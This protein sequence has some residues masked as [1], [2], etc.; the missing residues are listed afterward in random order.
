MHQRKMVQF[1][2]GACDAASHSFC[3][4]RPPPHPHR[5]RSG[6]TY[7]MWNSVSLSCSHSFLVLF[8]IQTF[9]N[10]VRFCFIISVRLFGG[11]RR[12]HRSRLLSPLS[13]FLI[14][15]FPFT[16]PL[17]RRPA[18][19]LLFVPILLW[20]QSLLLLCAL[21]AMYCKRA[22]KSKKALAKREKRR[23]SGRETAKE[24][25]RQREMEKMVNCSKRR[26]VLVRRLFYF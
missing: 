6:C 1:G 25:K 11:S 8:S 15:F 3:F 18:T 20:L 5:H 9:P 10:G 17:P 21:R 7:G 23:N 24:R 4:S 2:C 22:A 19:D 13:P 26:C 14:V 16:I 12:S